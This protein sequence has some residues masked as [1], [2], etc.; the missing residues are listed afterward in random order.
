MKQR[1]LNIERR[2]HA[3]PL[4]VLVLALVTGVVLWISTAGARDS[5]PGEPDKIWG[6]RGVSDGRLQKPRAA[7]IDEHDRI[8]IVDMLA[9]IQV[10]DTDG[11]LLRKPQRTPAFEFGKPTGLSIDLEGN[12]LVADTH[13]YRVLRYSPEGELLTE[14]TIG[15]TKGQGEG[16]FGLV[17]DAVVDSQGYVYVSE[18]GDFDRIQKFTPEGKFVKQWGGHGEEVGQFRRPQNMTIDENDNLWVVDACNHRVQVFDTEGNC[19]HVWGSYGSELGQLSY[20]YDI[21]VTDDAVYVCEFGNHR[22]QK[23][24]RDPTNEFK[25]A[26]TS[27]GTWGQAGHGEGEFHN[28]WAMVRD[29][30]GRIHVLDTNHHRVQRI[31]F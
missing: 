5:R 24:E 19:L 4:L 22:V 23:F 7:A 10:F 6:K 18:Y 26:P 31:Y 14:R 21:L 20:P 8:Y 3:R 13:Y 11:N 15:G 17:T 25:Q 9:R 29:S 12:L 27:I 30:H 2:G 28:P 16:E 1:Q